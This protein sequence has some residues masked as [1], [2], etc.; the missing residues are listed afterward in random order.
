[1]TEPAVTAPEVELLS[2]THV[3]TLGRPYL[4]YRKLDWW[5]R[6]GYLRPVASTR[7]GLAATPGSGYQRLF[8]PEEAAVAVLMARLVRAG[9]TTTAALAAARGQREL[10]PGIRL[11]LEE[12]S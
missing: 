8:T 3:V 6:C 1:M 2:S 12:A 9:L 5:V 7:P 11:V 10:G 4:T